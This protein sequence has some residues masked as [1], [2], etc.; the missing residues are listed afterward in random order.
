LRLK[1][2][3]GGRYANPGRFRRLSTLIKSKKEDLSRSPGLQ[4]F[5]ATYGLATVA[6]FWASSNPIHKF[7]TSKKS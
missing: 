3:L 6:F 1:G 5:P 2:G 4:G 7:D